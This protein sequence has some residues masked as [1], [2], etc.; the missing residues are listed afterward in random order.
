M[1]ATC[2][3]EALLEALD[4]TKPGIKGQKDQDYFLVARDGQLVVY[5]TDGPS[6]LVAQV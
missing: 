4:R 6:T 3:R 5:T 1:K 2:K